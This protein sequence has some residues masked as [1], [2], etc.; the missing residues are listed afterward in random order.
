MYSVSGLRR[1]AQTVLRHAL[2]PSN[3]ALLNAYSR[4]AGGEVTEI[5]QAAGV[6][7]R[8]FTSSL[9]ALQSLKPV[10]DQEQKA[11]SHIRNI[12]ISAHIDSG[13]TTTTERILFYT[14]RIKEIHEVG[15]MQLSPWS[16]SPTAAAAAAFCGGLLIRSARVYSEE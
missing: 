7:K 1:T 12:G 4:G 8:A 6:Q 3:Y 5:W 11:L 10:T 9:A 14:G 2:S 16:M 15:R 13:K